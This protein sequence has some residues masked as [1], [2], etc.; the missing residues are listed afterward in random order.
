MNQ[1]HYFNALK[2]IGRLIAIGGIDI[3]DGNRFD[4]G[5]RELLEQANRDREFFAAGGNE[6]AAGSKRKSDRPAKGR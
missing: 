6:V 5:E 2:L 4:S 3:T 1:N